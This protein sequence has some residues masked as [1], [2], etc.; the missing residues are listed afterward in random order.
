MRTI[1][2]TGKGQI[3]VHPDMTRIM[4]TLM[5]RYKDYSEALRH[6]AE[7]TESLRDILNG[8]G[9]ERSDLKTLHFH[10]DLW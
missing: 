6:S 5:D 8:L 10:A 4:I 1:R 7:D 9:F 3:R 2:V